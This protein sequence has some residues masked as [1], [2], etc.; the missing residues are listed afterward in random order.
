MLVGNKC[1]ETSLREVTKEEGEA[2][3]ATW[4]ISFMETSA[5]TNE[6]V[7]ELFQVREYVIIQMLIS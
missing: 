5:K 6:N 1:D 4:G 3:A 7:T 2:E